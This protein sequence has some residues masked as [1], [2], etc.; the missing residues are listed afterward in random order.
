MELSAKQDQ[1][2]SQ[3]GLTG[4]R[5]EDGQENLQWGVGG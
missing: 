2:M 3:T 1:S 4:S 5:L